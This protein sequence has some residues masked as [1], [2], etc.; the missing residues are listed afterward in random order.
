M[1]LWV[2]GYGLVQAI[3]PKLLGKH[4]HRAGPGGASARIWASVLALF[5]AG[6]AVGLHLGWPTDTLLISGL[7]LFGIVF[8]INSAL[9]SYLILAYSDHT[10]VAMNVGFYYMANAGGRLTGTIISGWAY[11]TQGLEACLWWSS[12]FV[13]VAALLSLGL[14][15]L[16]TTPEA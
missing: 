4:R 9:H 14:P 6:I 3:A 13:L 7:I 10:R 8:A 11:Q 16:K 2:I 15:E 12:T 5:P 1:A